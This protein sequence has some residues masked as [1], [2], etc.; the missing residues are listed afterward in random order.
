MQLAAIKAPTMVVRSWVER[1]AP[2]SRM[3]RKERSG[4]T[5]TARTAK[6]FL[7]PSN[8]A[9]SDSLRPS[10]K[11]YIPTAQ[12]MDIEA[13]FRYCIKEWTKYIPTKAAVIATTA[14]VTPWKKPSAPAV[15]AVLEA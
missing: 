5:L 7:V 11:K 15:A 1:A 3:G 9:A 12:S 14:D 10:S 2:V 13:I 4:S 8:A 6:S